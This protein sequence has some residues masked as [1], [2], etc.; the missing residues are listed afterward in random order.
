MSVLSPG[1]PAEVTWTSSNGAIDPGCVKRLGVIDYN[2]PAGTS[3]VKV[4][5]EKEND[6][7]NNSQLE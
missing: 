2:K 6:P 1:G 3:T 7:S 5:S 4:L